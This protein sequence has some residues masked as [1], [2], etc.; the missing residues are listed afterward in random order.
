MPIKE[1]KKPTKLAY[2]KLRFSVKVIV[3]NVKMSVYWQSA[4]P[5]YS[6]TGRYCQHSPEVSLPSIEEASVQKKRQRS[7]LLLYQY[8]LK[9]RMNSSHS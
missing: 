8:D 3:K 4:G 9:K 1:Q 7:S 6:L 2:L 5:C